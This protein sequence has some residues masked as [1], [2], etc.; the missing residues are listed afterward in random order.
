MS[1]KWCRFRQRCRRTTVPPIQRT[2]SVR[3][4]AVC[5]WA[6]A[7]SKPC[8]SR[9]RGAQRTNSA[10]CGPRVDERLRPRDSRCQPYVHCHCPS[11]VG[12]VIA[13]RET[14]ASLA[15][16]RR[17]VEVRDRFRHDEIRGPICVSV[18][19]LPIRTNPPIAHEAAGYELLHDALADR[20]QRL[21]VVLHRVRRLQQRQHA[22]EAIDVAARGLLSTTEPT[23]VHIYLGTIRWL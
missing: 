2:W 6:D 4:R 23:P 7:L 20:A 11:N 12:V 19:T 5:P 13:L 18:V 22:Q 14:N 10:I 3:A 15:G 17:T 8:A 1:W 16:D 21:H 9:Y